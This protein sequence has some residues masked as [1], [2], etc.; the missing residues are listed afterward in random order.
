LAKAAQSV[1]F[2]AITRLEDKIRKLIAVVEHTRAEHARIAGE[3]RALTDEVSTLRKR[4]V[5]SEGVGAELATLR[6]EREQVRARV[7]DM[8]SQIEALDL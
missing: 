8:L 5:D 6:E 1:E 7:S 4:L 2:D 3:H